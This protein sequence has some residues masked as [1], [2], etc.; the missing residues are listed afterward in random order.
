MTEIE[1]KEQV[2]AFIALPRRERRAKYD[3]LPEEVQQQARAILEARRGIA[4]REGGKIVHSKEVYVAQILRMAAKGRDLQKRLEKV[5][6]RTAALK[7][8]LQANY[9]DEALAEAE[10][11]L[12][13]AAAGNE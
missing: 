9:G 4:K 2:D 10:K 13:E 11:A 6:K 5:P 8:A 7:A 12:A 3:S 1:I